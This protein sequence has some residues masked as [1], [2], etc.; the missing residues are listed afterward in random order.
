LT[1]NTIRS[2]DTTLAVAYCRLT[3][4]V[5]LQR[6]LLAA[7]DRQVTNEDRAVLEATEPDA[8]LD[9]ASGE[10]FHMPSDRPGLVMRRK[11]AELLARHGEAEVRAAP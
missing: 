1:L 9:T 2:D 11:L 6:A 4:A 5:F 3:S 7:F 8:P 10:E